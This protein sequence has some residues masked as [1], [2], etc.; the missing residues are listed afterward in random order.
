RAPASAARWFAAALRLLPEAGGRPEQRV[1]LSAALAD[2]LAAV[3]RLEES[4]S[5]LLALLE[6]VPAEATALRTRLIGA[7]ATIEDLLGRHADAGARLRRA[8]GQLSDRSSPE[9][10]ALEL[11]L[12]INAFYKGDY[13]RMREY[14]EHALARGRALDER[15]LTA[16]ATATVALASTFVGDIAAGRAHAEDAAQ[17]LDAL[18]DAELA[19]RLD[20]PCYL[21][22][23]G[24]YLERYG[25]SLRHSARGI[26]VVRATGQ[27]QF[28]PQMIQAQAGSTVL[29]GR[30]AEA[31]ENEERAVEAARL[32]GNPQSLIWALMNYA[33]A[34]VARDATIALRAA[35]ESVELMHGLEDNAIFTMARSVHAMVLGELGDCE[36]CAVGLLAAAG[37]IGLPAIPPTWRPFFYDVLTRAELELGRVDAGDEAAAQAEDL[38]HGLGMKLP[39][40]W[41]QRARAR[42]LLAAGDRH[43]AA[44]LALASAAGAAAV[45][46]HVE[47][48]RS[49]ALCG[50]ALLDAGERERA[51][52]KLQAAAAQFDSC[53]AN[54]LRDEVERELRRLG[55]RFQRR[56]PRGDRGVGALSAREFEIAQLV[57]ARKTNREIA[58]ELFLS[59]KTVE[60]HLRNIFGKLGV[61][62]RRAVAHA[63]EQVRQPAP[64]SPISGP[65]DW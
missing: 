36:R 12:A 21:A 19:T 4:R 55:R 18:S 53:G 30:L 62:S 15:A 37:G 51:L 28:L 10:V 16:A 59:E 54:R 63:L 13:A 49:W 33:H 57:T 2:S 43:A 7:C 6:Q 14:A 47:V 34:M 60:T 25:E 26:A 42:V 5:T 27:G 64:G 44:D 61:S 41:A 29:S 9:A 22:W 56:A 3:G 32:T 38:A 11:E 17:L 31:A 35:E 40:G 46:A 23:A 45:G 8:L 48:A 52:A 24:L 58:A 39:Q 65:R 1:E 50:T 20:A